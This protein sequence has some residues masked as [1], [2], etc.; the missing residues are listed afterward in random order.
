MSTPLSIGELCT[1]CASLAW[2]SARLFELIGGWAPQASDDRLVGAFAGQARRHGWHA[3]LFTDQLPDSPSLAASTQPAPPGGGSGGWQAALAAATEL[4][5]S[6]VQ[7]ALVVHDVLVPALVAELSRL[8]DIVAGSSDR[9][10][11]RPVARVVRI[12]LD[13]VIDD[14]RALGLI[15]PGLL[16]LAADPTSDLGVAASVQVSLV[17][18]PS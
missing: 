9:D 8:D 4:A 15:R 10:A 13:D 18:P 6:D 1:R 5:R 7:R 2:L 3:E 12:V 16:A 11:G 17:A 14:W